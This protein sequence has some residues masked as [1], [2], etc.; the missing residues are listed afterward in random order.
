MPLRKSQYT[1]MVRLLISVFQPLLWFHPLLALSSQASSALSISCS[2]SH[3]LGNPSICKWQLVCLAFAYSTTLLPSCL[4]DGRFLVKFIPSITKTFGSM[5]QTIDI[6]FNTICQGHSHTFLLHINPSHLT[7]RPLLWKQ[8][9][10]HP[11]IGSISPTP[12]LFFMALLSLPELR[13]ITYAIIF[14]KEIGTS[15]PALPHA[16]RT[17]FLALTFGLTCMS[18]AAFMSHFATPPTLTTHVLCWILV[19]GNYTLDKRSRVK[20]TPSNPRFLFSPWLMSCSQK[21]PWCIFS[22]VNFVNKF[23]KHEQWWCLAITAIKNSFSLPPHVSQYAAIQV[24]LLLGRIR[25]IAF[26]LS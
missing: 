20:F 4:Q 26:H 3:S 21:W 13:G 11:A 12:I 8:N 2:L 17:L 19:T 25:E 22:R 18:I 5:L 7:M 6:G 10:L 24:N 1:I 16:F 14:P 15:Y 23:N 9:L